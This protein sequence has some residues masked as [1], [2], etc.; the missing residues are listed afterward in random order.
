MKLQ[1][2]FV[3]SAAFGFLAVGSGYA[4]QGDDTWTPVVQNVVVQGGQLIVTPINTSGDFGFVIA[5]CATPQGP[6]SVTDLTFGVGD[7][8]RVVSAS[9]RDGLSDP[10][11]DR[12]DVGPK[13]AGKPVVAKVD[14]SEL[15]QPNDRKNRALILVSGSFAVQASL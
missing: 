11:I 5:W 4:Q 13:T 15:R 12:G 7:T 9:S 10:D 2:L 3:L 14:R 6:C 8:A 1:K